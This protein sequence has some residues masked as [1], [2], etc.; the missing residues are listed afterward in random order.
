MTAY[1]T[2]GRKYHVDPACPR[3]IHGEDLHDCEGDDGW[4]AFTAGTYRREDPDPQHAAMRGKLPCLHCVPAELRVFPP[5]YGQTFGHEPE[6]A[7]FGTCVINV[8]ACNCPRHDEGQACT[9][10]RRDS[11]PVRWPCTSAIVLGLAPRRGQP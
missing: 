10:C 6:W 11:R 1:V 9:R 4:G 2:H 7:D 8:G 3:M 5:L